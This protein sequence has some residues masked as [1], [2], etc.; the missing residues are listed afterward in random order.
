MSNIVEY[1]IAFRTREDFAMD[2]ARRR[3]LESPRGQIAL[4]DRRIYNERLHQAAMI[5]SSEYSDGQA[6]LEGLLSNNDQSVA[7]FITTDFITAE[8]AMR[9]HMQAVAATAATEAI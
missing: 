7:D 3:W 8:Q 1:D 9:N 5:V 4:E 2:D 6:V